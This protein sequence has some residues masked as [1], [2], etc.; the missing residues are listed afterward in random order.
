MFT[1]F[2]KY[3]EV[4]IISPNSNKRLNWQDAKNQYWRPT[5][6][7]FSC[8]SCCYVGC[9]FEEF[10]ASCTIPHNWRK[11]KYQSRS[12][13]LIYFLFDLS[14]KSVT[15]I[16]EMSF[17]LAIV[18]KPSITATT[19]VEPVYFM[20]FPMTRHW[21]RMFENLRT[22]TT[23]I[24]PFAFMFYRMIFQTLVSGKPKITKFTLKFPF[25]WVNFHMVIVFS[26]C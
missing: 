9:I 24:W 4:S 7:W 18:C 22:Q 12:Q 16:Y 2:K 1:F 23:F 10:W 5:Y 26:N 3:Y 8:R 19:M 11:K 20:R 21:W 15:P 17:Q 13:L 25:E 6:R 14:I